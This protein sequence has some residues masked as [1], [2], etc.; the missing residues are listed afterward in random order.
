MATTLAQLADICQTQLADS[1]AGTWP[2]ATVEAWVLEAI[3]DY[4]VHFPRRKEYKI[5]CNDDVHEYPLPVD[6][7]DAILVEYPDG[8]DPPKY[9]ARKH[10]TD[11]AFWL[12][13]DHYDLYVTGDVTESPTVPGE[14]DNDLL[15]VSP[16]TATGEDIILQYLARH[17][18]SISS[19]D[20]VTVPARHFDLI[21]TFVVWRAWVERLGEEEQ[22]PDQTVLLLS[23]LASNADRAHRRYTEALN[24]AKSARS[25]SGIT[26]PW[27]SDVHDPIY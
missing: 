11:P 17:D 1:G 27:R 3:R 6:F 4:S 2:Q 16:E 19:G 8:E 26:E 22:A 13:D 12:S 7:L 15:I 25:E 14:S 23:Q 24:R 20:E 18:D 21:V 10:R 5:N 9:L